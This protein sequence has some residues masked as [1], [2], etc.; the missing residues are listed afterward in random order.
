MKRIDFTENAT[1]KMLGNQ[2]PILNGTKESKAM[3]D[4]LDAF[5]LDADEVTLTK[6]DLIY[7]SS[8]LVLLGKVLAE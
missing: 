7:L 5:G 4:V 8:N 1:T 6:S 3:L 2:E